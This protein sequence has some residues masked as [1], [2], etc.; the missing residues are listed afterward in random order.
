MQSGGILAD[1][2]LGRQTAGGVRVVFAPKLR[3]CRLWASMTA[4]E[5][6]SDQVLPLFEEPWSRSSGTVFSALF[7]PFKEALSI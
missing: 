5:A 3:C 2:T 6:T 1:A 7:F 4:A